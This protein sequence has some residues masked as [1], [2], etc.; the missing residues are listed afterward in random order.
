[1][2]APDIRPTGKHP[3]RQDDRK[4]IRG[5]T[6]GWRVP[7]QCRRRRTSSP[8]MSTGH[9]PRDPCRNGQTVDVGTVACQRVRRT[10]IDLAGIATPSQHDRTQNRPD[11]ATTSPPTRRRLARTYGAARR[12]LGENYSPQ[13]IH[14]LSSPKCWSVHLPPKN[15]RKTMTQYFS[16]RENG[17]RART[18]EEIDARTWGGLYAVISGR[19]D[20]ASVGWR[21][22]EQCPDGNGPCGYDFTNLKLTIEAE[23]PNIGLPLSSEEPPETI[24][25]LDLLE[26]V[27]ASVGEPEQGSFH[28]YYGHH[29]LSWKRDEGLARFVADVNRIFSRNGI[30]FELSEEGQAR[31]LLPSPMQ[32]ILAE[33][34]FQT[35]DSETDRLL[36]AAKRKITSPHMEDRRDALEKLWDAFERI[37]TLEPGPNKQAQA[38]ALLNHIGTDS[39]FRKAISEEAKQLTTIGNTFQIRHSETSQEPLKTS[40]QVDYL[41]HRMF[42]FNRLVLKASSRSG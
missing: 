27:A 19:M 31:R 5:R 39:K 20:D 29:H 28:S 26:F 22:P 40:D 24:D 7:S 41:A 18:N 35:G 16:D 38:E 23:I 37:K 30:A 17:P 42:S 13:R 8:A 3:S 11:V 21:F 1:M 34:F 9:A 14:T 36:E 32:D 2:R 33:T 6:A 25:A 12:N 10:G 15:N 4:A